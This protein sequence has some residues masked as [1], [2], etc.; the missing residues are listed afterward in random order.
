MRAGLGVAWCSLPTLSRFRETVPGVETVGAGQTCYVAF[1]RGDPG[2]LRNPGPV[3]GAFAGD[4]SGCD[5]ARRHKIA[6]AATV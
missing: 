1:E 4:K 6:A 5:V 2:A 3:S